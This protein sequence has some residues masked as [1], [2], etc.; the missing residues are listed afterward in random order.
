[1]PYNPTFIPG[2]N[3]P[4]PELSE[5]LKPSAFNGGQPIEHTRFSIVFN[6]DRGFAFLTA[7]N[8]DGGNLIPAG[9]IDRKSFVF[10]P[11]VPNNFQ[12]DNDRGY[13]INRWDRGHLVRRRSLHWGN[14]NDAVAA[15]RQSFFWTNIA[16]QHET[17]HDTA[18]GKVEDFI[19]E[20]SDDTSLAT[21]VFQ[22]PVLTPHDPAHQNKPNEQPIQIPAG[23]WKVVAIKH[24]GELRA[25]AFLI[26]QRDFDKP[27]PETFDPVLEQ[28]RITT[29]EFLTG[30]S[31]PQVLRDAD[32]F[33]Y[34]AQLSAAPGL[35]AAGPRATRLR[36][37]PP[38][39]QRPTFI[40]T[41]DDI[42]L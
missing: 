11:D 16:P 2:C 1:M 7:H 15:N 38:P 36:T 25:A 39:D 22:A 23:F 35:A 28:V 31:F 10:D 20:I 9:Q 8:I 12:I 24:Q 4:L 6:Q 33:H 3:I 14:F 19:L 40:R 29:V 37:G 27:E 17:L 30:L 32:P 42:R 18:W 5:E 13:H 26:W 41:A 34:S 21:A